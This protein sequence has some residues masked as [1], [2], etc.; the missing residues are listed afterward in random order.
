MYFPFADGTLKSELLV[1]T[2]SVP[3]ATGVQVLFSTAHT[4]GEVGLLAPVSTRAIPSLAAKLLRQ[5]AA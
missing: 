4:P 3:H 1:V 2:Y 5:S